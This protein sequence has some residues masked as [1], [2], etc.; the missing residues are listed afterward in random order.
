[1]PLLLHRRL[2]PGSKA[3]RRFDLSPSFFRRVV[4]VPAQICRSKVLG[5]LE[6]LFGV[7]LSFCLLSSRLSSTLVLS[8]EAHAFNKQGH[9]PLPKHVCDKVSMLIHAPSLS[10]VFV[11]LLFATDCKK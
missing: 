2:Q 10:W 9:Q 7:V 3:M 8:S 4:L 6:R 1:M 11:I 5:F